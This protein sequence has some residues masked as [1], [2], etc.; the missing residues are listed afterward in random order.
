MI[1]SVD[2]AIEDGMSQDDAEREALIVRRGFS[3]FV[4][5]N[6]YPYSSGH[7]LVVPYDHTDS[8]AKLPVETAHELILAAQTI[9][10]VLR[11]TYR[12]DGLNFGLNLG[13]AAG[14]GVASHLHLHALPRW[15]GDTNFMTSVAET[16]ILPETLEVTW[17]RLR[18]AFAERT[19]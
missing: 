16:R 3:I 5:L 6:R 10:S 4:C 7:L 19:G 17:Q 13:E 14:A 15:S 18:R 2:H 12:P 11:A 8:L 1:A 9:D